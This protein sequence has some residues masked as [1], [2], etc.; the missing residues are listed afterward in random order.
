MDNK[1]PL[2]IF[3]SSL[4]SNLFIDKVL[5]FAYSLDRM[6]EIKTTFLLDTGATNIA[7]IDLTMAH[8]MCDVLKISFI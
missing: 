5:V 8:H 3:A 4:S 2:L 1:K 7:F 6:N